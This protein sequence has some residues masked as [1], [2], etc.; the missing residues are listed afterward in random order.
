MQHIGHSVLQI[1]SSRSLP[2]HQFFR[3]AFCSVSHFSYE[4]DPFQQHSVIKRFHNIVICTFIKSI[5]CNLF[6]SHRC[7]NNKIWTFTDT[8]ILIDLIHDSQSVH[9]RHNQVEKNHIRIFFFNDPTHLLTI[10]RLSDQIQ[11]LIRPDHLFQ[12]I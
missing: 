1:F 4:F 2:G 6:L 7:N 3:S 10:F 11:F 5:F 8:F 9:F 12:Q